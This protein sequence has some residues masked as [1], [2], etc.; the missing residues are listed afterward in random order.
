MR[1]IP[2][3]RSIIW[4]AYTALEVEIGPSGTGKILIVFERE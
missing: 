3:A 1:E 2:K 4:L